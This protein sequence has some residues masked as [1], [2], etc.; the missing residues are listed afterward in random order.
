MKITG[1]R[2]QLWAHSTWGRSSVGVSWAYQIGFHD[3][4][5]MRR[6][7]HWFLNAFWTTYDRLR[8]KSEHTCGT[9]LFILFAFQGLLTAIWGGNGGTAA[10]HT[11]LPETA[12]EGLNV[13]WLAAVA[14]NKP[15]ASM[16]PW[17]LSSCFGHLWLSLISWYL[18]MLLLLRQGR[19]QQSTQSSF[20]YLAISYR[21][22]V[23]SLCI[24]FC[25]VRCPTKSPERRPA[26]SLHVRWLWYHFFKSK[27]FC[28]LGYPS[29]RLDVGIV[30][31]F[32]AFLRNYMA[33][34]REARYDHHLD[35]CSLYSC[36]RCVDIRHS[37]GARGGEWWR[38]RED[39]KDSLI[40]FR[41]LATF[42]DIFRHV[43]SRP[44]I[45]FTSFHHIS[46]LLSFN[47]WD[48]QHLAKNCWVLYRGCSWEAFWSRKRQTG[49][50]NFPRTLKAAC[51]DRPGPL[52]TAVQFHHQ[53]CNG[54]FLCA[55][56]VNLGS[57]PVTACLLSPREGPCFR[58]RLLD[59]PWLMQNNSSHIKHVNHFLAFQHWDFEM[60]S[61]D[62]WL[63][64][65]WVHTRPSSPAYHETRLDSK[66]D[67]VWSL[68]VSL[69]KCLALSSPREVD[70]TV[71]SSWQQ[72]RF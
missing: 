9:C 25:F 26:D 7:D 33:A 57:P 67:H 39:R 46:P 27:S 60:R 13:Q 66:L 65:G 19:G 14:L 36:M 20:Q 51:S 5:V 34:L 8:G 72:K 32:T 37:T 49:D 62:D 10:R 35:D 1:G 58:H 45:D 21:T 29:V 56:V 52:G 24:D 43:V 11:R 42:W 55:G 50:G 70:A 69:P 63:M 30:Y 59:H 40:G 15:W 48:W 53:C 23:M 47:L 16:S 71:F 54:Q 12:G 3:G 41:N 2:G 38:K 64:M 44:W 6:L 18:L 61:K 17:Y 68:V 28:A 31:N 22:F 4:I